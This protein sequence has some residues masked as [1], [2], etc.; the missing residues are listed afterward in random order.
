M[1]APTSYALG[2]P[3]GVVERS[4][5]EA[6]TVLGEDAVLESNLSGPAQPRGHHPVVWQVLDERENDGTA[7]AASSSARLIAPFVANPGEGT[8]L[9]VDPTR[10]DVRS[11]EVRRDEHTGRRYAVVTLRERPRVPSGRPWDEDLVLHPVRY[12]GTPVGL[13]T[14]PVAEHLPVARELAR[15]GEVSGYRVLDTKTGLPNV[16]GPAIALPVSR[17][18]R[19]PLHLDV[20]GDTASAGSR[21]GRKRVGGLELGRGVDRS[22]RARGVPGDVAVFLLRGGSATAGREH[23]A[24]FAQ[25]FADGS[26]RPTAAPTATFR[27]LH[28]DD[29][30]D[31]AAVAELGDELS[32]PQLGLVPDADNPSPSVQEFLPGTVPSTDGLATGH[33]GALPRWSGSGVKPGTRARWDAEFETALGNALRQNPWSAAVA[34]EAARAVVGAD[35][36]PADADLNVSLNTFANAAVPHLGKYRALDRQP[37]PEAAWWEAD[38]R[39]LRVVSGAGHLPRALMKQY[40]RRFRPDREN[41]MRFRNAVLA[42]LLPAGTYSLYDLLKAF[43]EAGVW[44]G[45][46]ERALVQFGTGPQLHHWAQPHF[47]QAQRRSGAPVVRTARDRA[48]QQR[49]RG[50]A[51]YAQE[52]PGAVAVHLLS[53]PGRGLLRI[54]EGQLT[55][56]RLRRLAR[57]YLDGHENHRAPLPELLTSDAKVRETL[58]AL[59]AARDAFGPG[60]AQT[61]LRRS[62]A[63]AAGV[64]E[65]LPTLRAEIPEH[66]ERARRELASRDP[67]ATTMWWVSAQPG[68][69]RGRPGDPLP[70]RLDAVRVRWAHQLLAERDTAERKPERSL[71]EGEH[72]VVY[73]VL[74]SEGSSARPGAIGARQGLYFR[75]TTL[76]VLSRTVESD[77]NGELYEYV[78][79]QESNTESAP[80]PG[81]AP[82]WESESDSATTAEP[83]PW[84]DPE[85]SAGPVREGGPVRESGPVPVAGSATSGPGPVKEPMPEP[86]EESA[87]GPVAESGAVPVAEAEPV[88]VPESV[89]G[90]NSPVVEPEPVPESA[91][92][93]M[94][95]PEPEPVVERASGPSSAPGPETGLGWERML[96]ERAEARARFRDQRTSPSAPRQKHADVEGEPA[97]GAERAS[98]KASERAGAGGGAGGRAQAGA[99]TGG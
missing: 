9:I 46:A 90:G 92:E 47:S 54:D 31:A 65:L 76:V 84:A 99:G 18:G 27:L 91:P 96:F 87:P 38:R 75:D 33:G 4:P 16:P 71:R 41:L 35:R 68:R 94:V 21:Y 19:V 80:A 29:A 7:F 26:T 73:E 93:P 82:E 63:L 58:D 50:I 5:L 74:P 56:Q 89:G 37:V 30:R 45:P 72:R 36:V 98:A 10:Y 78:Q 48:Y 12:E 42:W 59:D 81:S 40:R 64:E 85:P 25:R 83:E 24:G 67:I 22:L 60:S 49:T 55:P 66:Q 44:F 88:P 57:Q 32:R 20:T 6:G 2:G 1:D 97:A 13:S 17:A 69:L 61:A 15:F 77:A 79:V 52:D 14:L 11:V 95:E 43:H 8:T 51:P 34:R 3:R 70:G 86:V 62:D 23:G 39:G 28:P 53:G